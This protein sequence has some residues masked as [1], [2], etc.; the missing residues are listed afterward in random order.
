M[1]HFDLNFQNVPGKYQFDLV[2]LLNEEFFMLLYK[3]IKK[4]ES[5]VI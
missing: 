3:K 5:S 2:W 4:I 1:C